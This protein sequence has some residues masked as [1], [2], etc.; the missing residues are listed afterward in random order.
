[1]SLSLTV[2]EGTVNFYLEG[3]LEFELVCLRILTCKLRP[4][5]PVM[6]ATGDSFLLPV[7]LLL[8]FTVGSWFTRLG[9]CDA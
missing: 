5:Q 1:M 8:I 7:W 6:K 2:P 9:H 3:F 4:R